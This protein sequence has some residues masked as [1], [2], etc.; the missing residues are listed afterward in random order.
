MAYVEYK[1]VVL[2]REGVGKSSMTI[3]LM[4]YHFV[5]EH[6]PTIED[7]YRKQVKW[8]GEVCLLDVLDTAG[9]SQRPNH[10]L[11]V[12]ANCFIQGRRSI[13]E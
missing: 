10:P 1:L 12:N 11:I 2:G 9:I 8:D 5:D 13:P 6:D 7:I 3:Q 4:S